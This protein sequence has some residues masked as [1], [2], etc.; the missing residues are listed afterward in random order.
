LRHAREAT[1]LGRSREGQN[2][3]ALWLELDILLQMHRENLTCEGVGTVLL[4][5]VAGSS[6][7][8]GHF[9]PQGHQLQRCCD[10]LAV[11]AKPPAAPSVQELEKAQRVV[12][13]YGQ[14]PCCTWRT[15]CASPTSA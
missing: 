14:C 15:R 9:N 1:A 6:L 8:V 2:Q 11:A 13:N 7:V 10:A 4:I 3:T 5:L 12:Q